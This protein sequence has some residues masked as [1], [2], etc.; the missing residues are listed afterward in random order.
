LSVSFADHE[1]RVVKGVMNS[2]VFNN[3][4]V[5]DINTPKG[6]LLRSSFSKL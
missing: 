6:S 2:T 5:N 4:V 3:A 1:E